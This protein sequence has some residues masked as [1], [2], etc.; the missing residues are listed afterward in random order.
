MDYWFANCTNLSSVEIGS[1]ITRLGE[2]CFY[3]CTGLKTITIPT[4]IIYVDKFVFIKSGL[5]SMTIAGTNAWST[6]WPVATTST[7]AEMTA[8][9]MTDSSSVGSMGAMSGSGACEWS[10]SATGGGEYIPQNY[11]SECGE[12]LRGGKCPVCNLTNVETM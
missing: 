3:N 6:I 1:G 7:N 8:A 4:N 2:G 11:C 9:K 12:A 10:R 5:T